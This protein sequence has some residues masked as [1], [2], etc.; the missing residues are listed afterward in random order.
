MVSR[1]NELKEFIHTIKNLA[2]SINFWYFPQFFGAIDRDF[3][4]KSEDICFHCF[5]FDY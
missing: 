2:F 4:E 5:E 3:K 1:L